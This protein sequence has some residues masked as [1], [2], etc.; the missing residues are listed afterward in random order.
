MIN[1]N[2]NKQLITKALLFK[3]V[4]DWEIFRKYIDTEK[5]IQ[6]NKVMLSPLRKENN[7]SFGLFLGTSGEICFRDHVLGISGDCVKLVQVKYNL[8]FFE[9]MSKIA[10]DFDFADQYI[11]KSFEKTKFTNDISGFTSRAEVINSVTALTLGKNS[12]AWALHDITYWEQFGITVKTLEHFN[13]QP[14]SYFHINGKAYLADKHAYCFIEFKDGKETYKFYQPFNEKYK[15]INGHDSSVWQGWDK[16][17]PKGD[18]LIITKSLKD[19]MALYDVCGIAGISLQ[20][21]N[22]QP[23]RHVFDQL[24]DRFAVKYLLYDN[25]YDKEINWGQQFAEKLATDL[26]LINIFIDA[27]YKS[28]DFSDLVKMVG[29]DKARQILTETMML[30][31]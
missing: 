31:F 23:K 16:L 8:T 21:E 30:P 20:S 1:L 25:D 5:D 24:D 4:T 28:K 15:W 3:E 22:T 29:R 17:P 11:C 27:D 9:A 10:I 2:Q 26:G 14:I 13:V 12:R 19:V 6:I 18:D 7:P